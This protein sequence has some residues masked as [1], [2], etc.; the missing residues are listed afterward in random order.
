MNREIVNKL[1]VHIHGHQPVWDQFLPFVGM[2]MRAT[3]NCSTRFTPN[4]MMLGQEVTLPMDFL[5]DISASENA[6]PSE[7]QYVQQI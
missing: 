1:R 7:A 5:A 2:A 3:V 4:M 6:P